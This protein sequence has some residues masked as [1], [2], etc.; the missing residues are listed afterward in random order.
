MRSKLPVQQQQG[1]VLA[2]KQAFVQMHGPVGAVHGFHIGAGVCPFMRQESGRTRNGMGAGDAYRT[3]HHGGA[4]AAP[5][6]VQEQEPMRGR[7]DQRLVAALD[8]GLNVMRA[9]I[10]AGNGMAGA[11]RVGDHRLAIH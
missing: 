5:L 10:N 3:M 2:F 9:R 6:F 7:L 8:Q 4:A 1:C 11:G